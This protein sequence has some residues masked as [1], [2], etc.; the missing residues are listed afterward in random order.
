MRR[1]VHLMGAG[2]TV[3]VG[4]PSSGPCLEPQ[5]RQRLPASPTAAVGG[6]QPH[7]TR[8]DFPLDNPKD[9]L[10]NFESSVAQSGHS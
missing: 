5:M 10:P 7:G 8:G 3:G 9:F 1:N 2:G 4:T 6:A